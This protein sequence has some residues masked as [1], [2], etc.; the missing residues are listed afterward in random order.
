[1]PRKLLVR[2]SAITPPVSLALE[3]TGCVAPP[4]HTFGYDS[5]SR[6][7]IALDCSTS[8]LRK[9]GAYFRSV[10]LVLFAAGLFA[11]GTNALPDTA[12]AP[13]TDAR[14]RTRDGGT[15]TLLAPPDLGLPDSKADFGPADFSPFELA[16]HDLKP[17]APS[18]ACQ[19]G[20]GC[21]LDKCAEN[22]QCQSGWCVEHMGEGVCS[23]SC[24]DECP[25]GWSCKQVGASDPDLLYVCV[26]N[27]SNL[28]KP[29]LSTEGCQAAGG[30]QDVC[31]AYG[32]DGAFCGGTCSQTSDC[33][34]GFSC[35]TTVTVDGID[36][37]Q[38]VSDAGSCSCTAKSTALSLWTNCEVSN[39]V[40]TC[41][42]KRVCAQA[43]LT[44]CDA[45]VPTNETCNG[46]DDD[47]DDFVD[48]PDE[49]Q[50]DFINLCDDGNA[51]TDDSC[52]GE[53]GC[54]YVGLE[55]GECID[56]DACTVADHC[57]AGECTGNPVL[58]DDDNV[59][60]D[61][62][63]DGSGGCVFDDNN[64]DCDDGNPCTVAD[65]CEAGLCAGT[66]VP[67]DCQS[68]DDCAALEDGD[69]CNGTLLCTLSDWPYE[70]AIDPNTVVLCPEPQ[71]GPNAICSKASCDPA[72]G[73]CSILPD[74]D[75]FAC[76]DGNAC[77]IGDQCQNGFCTPG[78]A[79]NCNDGNPCTDDSCDEQSGCL[80]EPNQEPCSDGNVCTT[81][82][83]CQ[84]GDCIAG[85]L[86]ACD[87]GNI[88]TM[89]TCDINIGCVHQPAKGT[90]CDDGNLCTANDKCAEGLCA[91]GQAIVC[92]DQNVCTN[93]GCESAVGCVFE[94][95]AN[96]CDDGNL[97]TLTDT[98]AQ[99]SCVGEGLLQCAD[100]NPCTEDLCDPLLGCLF[101]AS[102]GA[103]D[104]GN[105]CTLGDH[106][107]GGAC[108]TT[109]T[110]SCNDDN[111]CTNDSC[112]PAVGCIHTLNSLPCDDNDAC[113]NGDVCG[114]GVCVGGP[115]LNC[116]DG[117]ICTDDQCDSGTGCIYNNNSGPCQDGNSCTV[118]DICS[119][120][121]CS[122]GSTVV[123][124]D[125]NPCTDDSCIPDEGC[126]FSPNAQSCD[127][128]NECTVDDF[129]SE[130]VCQGGDALDCND[131]NP[132]T[133]ES[134]DVATGCI[135][136]DNE[137]PCEDG[138]ECTLVDGCLDGTCVG[139]GSPVCD[140]SNPCTDDTCDP[141]QGCVFTP[142]SL[143]CNDSD[144]CT[145]E[146]TCTGGTCIGTACSDVGQYCVG[147][148]CKDSPC[149]GHEFG[150]YCWHS[151]GVGS[152]CSSICSGHGGCAAQGLEDYK[153]IKSC[154]VCQDIN[155][156]KSCNQHGDC[157]CAAVYPGLYTSGSSWCGYNAQNCT[158]CSTAKQCG[159]YNVTRYCPCMN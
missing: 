114:G 137:D 4:R 103:C 58:C 69:F 53:S 153:G 105:P 145:L 7:A 55:E 104:D 14:L 22:G 142:N 42:G 88:C 125:S 93:D 73:T 89:D 83:L 47:C 17:D 72:T 70:C 81:N 112:D 2:R 151:G 43:G 60:T 51:C 128:G 94:L 35:L 110:N 59:C 66:T 38:C 79:P 23:Q 16:P 67:C 149:E 109:A 126:D 148:I 26:S 129:C 74:H 159:T 95:N 5:S 96:P 77:T 49:V 45:P 8:L 97:C 85:A 25:Q 11:C 27:Y 141:D 3:I 113:T 119:E 121:E 133:D 12:A 28:C 106:C 56:G 86:L 15:D 127:D 111:P 19:P 84:D 37:L 139:T 157:K 117:N 98:C 20:E 61:D 1:M 132:C 99:G 80:A 46:I 54:D 102:D 91:P 29:C 33:P 63:C 68:Q 143:P 21:F 100:N 87:D 32:D 152:S 135:Y 108:V 39:D 64:S 156:G 71:P 107:D 34:W 52:N 6:L 50:G 82:D 24:V 44:D 10:S 31:V 115:A 92:D 75:G 150:G 30:A 146:D 122:P 13:D 9:L 101:P 147:G 48:E 41:A 78:V 62:S 57:V 158:S 120:G 154:E 36:T 40:G 90:E 130:S 140:D 118:S 144:G 18:P 134:C 138:S 76:A 131:S 136:A 116:N 65:E 155:P 123:C 124:N